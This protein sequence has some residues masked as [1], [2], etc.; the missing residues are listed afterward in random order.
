MSLTLL[1]V[2]IGGA[3]GAVLRY[4]TGLAAL[5]MFGAAFPVGTLSVNVVGS[6]AMGILAIWLSGGRFS[7]LLMTGLLGGFTT[8]SAFSLD[9]VTLWEKGQ[10]GAAALYLA[11]SGGLSI[12]ALIAG[13]A[14]AKGISP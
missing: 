1:Q 3:I 10:V 13:V 7:P 6:F 5:R 9:V 2:A 14:F 11:A 12:A 8:F 4:M